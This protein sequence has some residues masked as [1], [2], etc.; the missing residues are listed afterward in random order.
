VGSARE[1]EALIDGI[2]RV[3]A[4]SAFG[5]PVSAQQRAQKIAARWSCRPMFPSD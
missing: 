4:A 1:L 5:R 2:D 3:T